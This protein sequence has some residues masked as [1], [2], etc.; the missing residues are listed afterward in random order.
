MRPPKGDGTRC[1]PITFHC[2]RTP[3]VSRVGV[4][5]LVHA[6]A[7]TPRLLEGDPAREGDDR[8]EGKAGQ[9]MLTPLA[10]RQ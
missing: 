8:R 2:D 10:C 4:R 1:L 7:P 6:L 5:A 3:V 9:P